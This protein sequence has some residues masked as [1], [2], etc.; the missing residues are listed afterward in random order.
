MGMLML[1][2]FIIIIFSLMLYYVE[3]GTPCFYGENSCEFS[4][5]PLGIKA[6]RHVWVNK[7]GNPSNFPN[8]FNAMWFSFVTA[9]TVGYGDIVPITNAGMIVDVVLMLTGSFYMSMPL[10]VS[11]S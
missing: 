10:T 8:A 6:G 2:G 5:P 11:P 7:Q 9:T 4:S 3:R 1:F